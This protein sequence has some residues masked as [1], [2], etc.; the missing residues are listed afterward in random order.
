MCLNCEIFLRYPHRFAAIASQ[1]P[2]DL[3]DRLREGFAKSLA[4]R[5][6]LLRAVGRRLTF[7]NL[8]SF[9][10]VES[11]KPS[12][13]TSFPGSI[14]GLGDRNESSQYQYEYSKLA[15]GF[16]VV[17]FWNWDS[18][19]WNDGGE[20]LQL[21]FELFVDVCSTIRQNAGLQSPELWFWGFA[22]YCG[23]T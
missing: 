13:V 19:T 15:C 1:A 17:F 18:F 21:C 8:R 11:T 7:G 10:W 4:I 12:K 14:G 6:V 22:K 23:P 20:L 5:K 2:L 16:K 9:D 3:S